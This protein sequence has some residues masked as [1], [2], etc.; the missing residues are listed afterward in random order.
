VG[1]LVNGD[2]RVAYSPTDHTMIDSRVSKNPIVENV[3]GFDVVS[4]F[5]RVKAR[6]HVADGNPLI[7][8]LKKAN[9]Y[10]VDLENILLFMPEFHSITGLM[11]RF[12][13]PNFIVPIPSSST[14]S[15]MFARRIGRAFEAKVEYE[16][17]RKKFNREVC[18][19]IDH[20]IRMGKVPSSDQRD[21]K[22][23]RA[24]LGRSLSSI[25]T[26]KALS[27]PIRAYVEPFKLN[28]SATVPSAGEVV[29]VDDLLS[30]G[31]SLLC[32]KQILEGRGLSVQCVCLFSS[33][34]RYAKF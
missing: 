31:S 13:A 9:G 10:S 30:T 20:L 1:I 4:V 29:L 14:V 32:A 8:A 17:L 22:S 34:G 3:H 6:T 2:R 33:T 11:S 28:S 25:F 24:T 21:L 23:V 15:E 12:Y 5:R 19:D 16:W 27:A 18:S 26:M 7:Y